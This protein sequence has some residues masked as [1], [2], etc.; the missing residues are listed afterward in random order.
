M[1]FNLDFSGRNSLNWIDFSVNQV[2]P[3]SRTWK[4]SEIRSEDRIGQ[5]QIPTLPRNYLKNKLNQ[6]I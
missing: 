4:S 6:S 5:D 1:R 2:F 3:R